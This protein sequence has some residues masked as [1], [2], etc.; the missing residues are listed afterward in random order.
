MN[1]SFELPFA[2]FAN[3]HSRANSDEAV[4]SRK[5]CGAVKSGARGTLEGL[6]DRLLSAD[7]EAIRASIAE[8]RY[9][10]PIPGS[11]KTTPGNFWGPKT[12]CDVLHSKGIGCGVLPIL[13]RA[14]GVQKSAFAAPG[15]RPTIQTHFDS[16][17][18]DIDLSTPTQITLVDDVIT[19][20]ATMMAAAKLIWSKQPNATIYGFAVFRTRNLDPDIDSV[21]APSFGSLKHNEDFDAVERID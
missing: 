13:E 4:R 1:L 12:I 19:K 15:D 7:A 16:M 9:L 10:V 6:A 17:T 2:T 21:V 18:A 11:G 3:Y 5:L 14:T 20:G 8:D